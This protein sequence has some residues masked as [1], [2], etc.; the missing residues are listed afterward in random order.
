MARLYRPTPLVLSVT[1]PCSCSDV[2]TTWAPHSCPSVL[3]RPTHGIPPPPFGNS[4]LQLL[5]FLR[6]LTTDPAVLPAIKDAGAI[7]KLIPL[8]T[9]KCV[10]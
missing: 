2:C 8:L 9:Y 4:S 10:G 6:N 3:I 1:R 7:E 5:R